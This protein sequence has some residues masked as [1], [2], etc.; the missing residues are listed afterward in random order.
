MLLANQLA[1]FGGGGPL[2]FD[3]CS[4]IT[5]W[6]DND[7]GD[8]VSSQAAAQGEEVFSFDSGSG[9]GNAADRS[10]N[11]IALPEKFTVSMRLYH[12]ALGAASAN[13]HFRVIVRRPDVALRASFGTDGL[14]MHTGTSDTD[15]EVGTNIVT[16]GQWDTWRF[17]TDTTTA[18][19]A[20]VDVY[21]NGALQAAGVDCSRTGSFTNGDFLIRQLGETTANRITYIDWITVE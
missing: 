19:S 11:T 7:I 6:A 1:G 5:P 13:D 9:A 4:D 16:A 8:G 21:L 12:S 17:V 2:F 14:F 18:A 3:D 15:L 20:T 10:R